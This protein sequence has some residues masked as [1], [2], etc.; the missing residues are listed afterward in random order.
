MMRL[1]TNR[2]AAFLGL[3]IGGEKYGRKIRDDFEREFRQMMP[4]GSLYTTLERMVKKG[5]LRSRLGESMHER[6]GYRRKF[7]KITAPGEDALH[8]YD[9]WKAASLGVCSNGS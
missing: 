2:E 6:G 5:F 3:L 4:L 9:S 7:Y 8:A 1:P